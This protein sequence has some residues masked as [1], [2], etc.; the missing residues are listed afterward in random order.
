MYG[1]NIREGHVFMCSKDGL[2]QQFDVWPDQWD[3]KC[4]EAWDRIHTYYSKF[5]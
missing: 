5:T 3:A 1:T 2:Y 4:H